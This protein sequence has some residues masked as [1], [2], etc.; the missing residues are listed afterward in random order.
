MRLLEAF[1]TA[2]VTVV[3]IPALVFALVSLTFRLF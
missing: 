2:V 1:V 3:V